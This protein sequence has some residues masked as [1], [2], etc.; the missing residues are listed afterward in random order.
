M[1]F[2]FKILASLYLAICFNASA[3]FSQ[4]NASF[5]ADDTTDCKSLVAIFHNSSGGEG[6]LTYNWNFGNNTFST[7][8]NPTALY[9]L[10]GTYTVTLIASNGID[11]DTLIKTNYIQVFNNPTA[12]F[13]V[14]SSNIGCTPLAVT[15][16]SSTVS[17]DAGIKNRVWDFGDG[18]YGYGDTVDHT[19]TKSN[20][21]SVTL[22]IED[23]N[24]CSHS[25][26]KNNLITAQPIPAVAFAASPNVSCLL[27]QE[28][29]FANSTVGIEPMSF[30]WDFGVGTTGVERNPKHVY[31]GYG[32]YS[33]K[34]VATNN[35]GCKD[36]LNKTN[37]IQLQKF[38]TD[39]EINPDILCRNQNLNITN[40]T[41]GSTT[42]LWDFGDGTSSNSFSPIKSYSQSGR[43][44]I[45]YIASFNSICF[46]TVYKEVLVDSIKANFT[47]NLHY[48]CQL[49][50]EVTYSDQSVNAAIWNWKFG[51][52]TVSHV[53]NPLITYNESL[54]LDSTKSVYI[55]D[56]LIVASEFGCSD[57]FHIDSNIHVWLPVV[58]FTPNNNDI[59]KD[60]MSGC[61][62]LTVNFIDSSKTFDV[63]NPL[64]TRLWDFGDGTTSTIEKPEHIYNTPGTFN[65]TLTITNQ[66]G[67]ENIF[68]AKVY[69]GTPQIADF[70][71]VGDTVVCGSAIV[72]FIDL[73]TDASLINN[74]VWDFGDGSESNQ[75]HPF[76]RFLGTGKKTV[77]LTVYYN[78]CKGSEKTVENIIEILPP[79][80]YFESYFSC[81]NPLDVQFNSII[82]GTD[83]LIWNFGDNTLD[84]TIG[85]GSVF[86]NHVYQNTGVYRVEVATDTIENSCQL[87][88]ANYIKVSEPIADFEMS[89]E[90]SC[91]NNSIT[92]DPS[93]SEDIAFFEYNKKAGYYLWDFGDSSPKII[94][95]ESVKHKY[96][97]KGTY[98][99]SLIIRDSKSCFDTISKSIQITKPNAAFKMDTT[100]GCFPLLVAFT[101]QSTS[102]TAI[103]NWNWTFGDGNQA[104]VKNPIHTY[105][106]GDSIQ[107]TLVVT[108]SLGCKDTAINNSLIVFD[109]PIPIFTVLS[110]K[111]CLGDTL[112]FINQTSDTLIQCTWDFGD[113]TGSEEFAPSHYY[114][115]TGYY[116]ITL[117]I[118]N[119]NG[120]DSTVTVPNF[121]YVSPIPQSDFETTST[122]SNCYPAL[123]EFADNSQGDNIIQWT[124][125]F[126]DN[127]PLEYGVNPIH[128]Y[129]I[130]GSFTV[131]HSIKNSSGCT[132]IEIKDNF[133]NV[134]GPYA[135]IVAPDSGCINSSI[136]IKKQDTLN[137]DYF[138]WV[139][140]NGNSSTNDSILLYLAKFRK[141]YVSLYLESDQF[142]TCDKIIS[143]SVYVP[144]LKSDFSISDSSGC[145]PKAIEFEDSSIGG[146]KL[147]WY[148]NNGL[149]SESAKFIY[150]FS[151]A[152]EQPVILKTT[153]TVGCIDS[154][155]KN[156]TIFPLPVIGLI[157]EVLLCRDDTAG[158]TA[159]GGVQYSWW[160]NSFIVNDS[161]PGIAVFPPVSI[162]Y[163]LQVKDSNTCINYD[164]VL[165]NVQQ[166]PVVTILNNDT[167]SVIIGEEV[168][169]E[170][171]E[172]NGASFYWEPATYLDCSTCNST[173]G[174]PLESTFYYFF[175]TDENECFLVKDS[176]YISVDIK[177]SVDL[178]T[179]FSPNGDE[180]NDRVFVKGWGIQ[181]LLEFKIFDE[182]GTMV[183]NSTNIEEGWD[184]FYHQKWL[185]P[186]TYFYLVSV[187]FYDHSTETKKGYIYLV[188]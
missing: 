94:T 11:A 49:P 71:M 2:T 148:I 43:F 32:Q 161:V 123:F 141:Y 4:V 53:Q 84:T 3:L 183:Y 124:W 158:I 63:N 27:E 182:S 34:L 101:D 23:S 17:G 42:S 78:Q 134:G 100:S 51:D 28:V 36:S 57:E 62:P 159:S 30:I 135:T 107:V 179:A 33:V 169:L 54:L 68:E 178:P 145:V 75:A 153:S 46:D 88:L 21:Y 126:G 55:S 15:F 26:T 139:I 176:I 48:S 25:K 150:T 97:S 14:L 146:S 93:K 130:P 69:V 87:L 86:V 133:V 115:D 44:T 186:G 132:D 187:E 188:K 38:T 103:A 111:T 67:C 102:D 31:S 108:D 152:G 37:L 6:N 98:N 95:T 144:F 89:S 52:G 128:S 173:I 66:S 163:Y 142:G 70:T 165:V 64:T 83:T 18:L 5:Y 156:V 147:K 59:Y 164:S 13:A 168:L 105:S 91:V 181:K 170:T 106:I 112:H 47:A 20:T 29:T 149:V 114:V 79:A 151:D 24:N 50:F 137:I 125:D 167:V 120:C 131:A 19:Y 22:F 35:I 61:A 45:S 16:K 72:E 1:N 76:H 177:Y 65:V 140:D 184:G 58:Y 81:S 9:N 39:I 117:F 12:D 99:V 90:L 127:S 119:S 40:N 185:N 122:I 154:L 74:W 96:S 162:V 80:G 41:L 92:F 157:D 175:A 60:K 143:D 171:E 172:I 110:N 73:S 77:S 180:L 104:T 8:A 85:T 136:Y 82:Q 174:T 10:P 116:N 160:P 129:L 138:N 56:T 118:I 121:I 113:G 155:Q 109:T 166:K 7:V